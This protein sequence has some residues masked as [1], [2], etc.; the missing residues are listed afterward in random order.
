METYVSPCAEAARHARKD[1]TILWSAVALSN[2][3]YLRGRR[4]EWEVKK[5]LEADGW[6]V[7]RTAGSHGKYDLIAVRDSL[8]RFIQ[9]KSVDS[10]K[11]IK[12]Y[13][14]AFNKEESLEGNLMTSEELLVK[15]KG[16]KNYAVYY[17]ER[18]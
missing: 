8:I 3:H 17:R 12:K 2:K 14:V 18:D 11:S 10:D 9:C 4:F 6:M 7:F 16:S 13:V 5:E 15:V 1:L